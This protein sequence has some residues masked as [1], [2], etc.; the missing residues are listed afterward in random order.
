VAEERPLASLTVGIPGLVSVDTANVRV[1][2]VTHDSRDAGPGVIFAAIKGLTVDGHEFVLQAAEA[3]SPAVVVERRVAIDIPQIVVSDSRTAMAHLAATVHGRPADTLTMIGV[4]GTNG[5]TTVSAMCEAILSKAGKPVG[6][7]GTLGARL[8]GEPIPLERTTPESTDLQRLLA[9]MRT[10]G[11]DNV[12]ME[13]SS[14][15]MEL[16]RVDAICFDVAAFTNLSQDHLDFHGDMDSYFAAKRKLFEPE[17]CTSAVVNI[18]DKAGR[19]LAGEIKVPTTTVGLARDADVSAVIVHQSDTGSEFDIVEGGVP[20]R[21]ALPLAG[22]FNVENAA[23]AYAICRYLSVEAATIA[24]GLGSLEPIPGRMQLVSARAEIAVIVDYAHTPAAVETVV[25][26]ARSMTVG[27]VLVVLGA[28]GDRDHRKRPAM[29]SSAATYADLTIVTTDNPRS[30]DPT[31]IASA[32]AQGARS[33]QGATVEVVL[34]RIDAIRY[35][36]AAAEPGD[37]VLILGRGH[38]QGQE[39]KGNVIP[40]SDADV[41]ATA[42]HDLGRLS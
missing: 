8:S 18:S 31:A 5:K 14:H 41:A 39:V 9:A 42:L 38:E 32:V 21:I 35:A 26:A 28:G 11:V 24:E 40:L 6:I 36:I 7:V 33:V 13:V 30:E 3:G 10:R 22:S 23:I 34:D 1:D 27:R 2:D 15:A 25:N 4:T 20:T 29:G 17:R 19:R 37:V 12:I 16:G